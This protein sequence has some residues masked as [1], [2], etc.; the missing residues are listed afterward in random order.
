MYATDN[1]PL[2]G[3]IASSVAV[4]DRD[5]STIS[6]LQFANME[7]DGHGCTN[8]SGESRIPCQCVAGASSAPALQVRRVRVSSVER[9]ATPRYRGPMR[10]PMLAGLL[11]VF[12]IACHPIVPVVYSPQPAR[13]AD[14]AA[15]VVSL[16]RANSRQGCVTSAEVDPRLVSVRFV[17]SEGIGNTV[18]RLDRIQSIVLQQSGAWYRVLVHHS[19]GTEDFSWTFR[20]LDDTERMA[21]ALTA[22]SQPR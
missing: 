17:C 18:A 10:I 3:S 11:L 13:I 5:A 19:D 2:V 16:I 4:T 12:L 21:D 15:E 7:P 14:P 20:S 9:P 22:L 6:W 8:P 1:W